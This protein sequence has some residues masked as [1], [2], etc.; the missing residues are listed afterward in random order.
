MSG[1]HADC[2]ERLHMLP[3][4]G[5]RICVGQLAIVIALL[6]P[7]SGMT[8]P[9]CVDAD[10]TDTY[11]VNWLEALAEAKCEPTMQEG[12]MGCDEMS[13]TLDRV[14]L[15]LKKSTWEEGKSEDFGQYCDVL[16][17]VRREMPF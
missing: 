12:R 16:D 13:T 5:Q 15:E 8:H 9:L 2:E 4:T 6:V 10:Q 17:T 1:L 14:Q 7:A 3:A 11:V